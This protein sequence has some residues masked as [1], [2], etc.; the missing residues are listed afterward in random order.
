MWSIAIRKK[1]TKF[2]LEKWLYISTTQQ[3]LCLYGNKHG[4]HHHPTHRW[5]N[6]CPYS[7]PLLVQCLA[8]QRFIYGKEETMFH[9][10]P[11]LWNNHT[12]ERNNILKKKKK[13]NG[14]AWLKFWPFK[15]RIWHWLK[16]SCIHFRFP[17]LF[18]CTKKLAYTWHDEFSTRTEKLAYTGSN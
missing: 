7:W 3:P 2:N 6:P 12:F 11:S 13:T 16:L 5:M 15:W 14:A 8:L 18:W 4:T 17:V 9:P 1:T 10:L